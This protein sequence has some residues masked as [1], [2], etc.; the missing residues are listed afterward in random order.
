MS[1][2]PIANLRLLE[3]LEISSG[4]QAAVQHTHLLLL[5]S[6]IRQAQGS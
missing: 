2:L 1:R 6:I 4:L 5:Y 3:M